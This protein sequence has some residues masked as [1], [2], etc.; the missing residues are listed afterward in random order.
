M[1]AYGMTTDVEVVDRAL[2]TTRAVRL[3]L[4]LERIVDIQI[5]Y[6]CIDVAE[7]APTGGNQGSRRWIVVRDPDLKSRLA[8][9]Y[10]EAAHLAENLADVPL[11][12]IPTIIG[13]HDSSGNPGLFDSVIQSAWSFC[14]ALRARGLGTAWTTAVLAKDP[15][16]KEL[17]DIPEDM[18]EI[19]MLP[20][21]WTVG[22]DFKPAARHDARSITDIDLPARFSDEFLGAAWADPV[23]GAVLGA[24]FVGRNER[25]TI[26]TWEVPC[27][28]S[29]LDP[30]RTFAWVTSDADNPGARWRFDLE[31]IAGAVRLRFSVVIGPG[32]SGITAAVQARPEKESRIIDR[33]MAEHRANMARVVKGISDLVEAPPE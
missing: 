7:Q 8:D 16:L 9:L 30:R 27:Y 11:I 22:N 6:D 3:R 10:N 20:V 18:T 4:D 21:A 28:I 1:V 33:R 17:L 12:V 23:A 32:P 24:E 5:V 14:V 31:P 15:E 13:R 29:D 2:T 25:P 26:G 19:A